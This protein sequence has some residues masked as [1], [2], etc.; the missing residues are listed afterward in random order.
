MLSGLLKELR[1]LFLASRCNEV[2]E[3]KAH[4]LFAQSLLTGTELAEH[5]ERLAKSKVTPLEAS[6]FNDPKIAVFPT[7]SRDTKCIQKGID[8]DT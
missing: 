1:V 3:P 8:H 7:L 4:E 2:M 5:L 6:H